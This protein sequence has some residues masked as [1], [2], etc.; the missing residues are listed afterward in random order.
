MLRKFKIKYPL[1]RIM[2]FMSN[3]DYCL[4]DVTSQG[5]SESV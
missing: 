1:S 2:F 4:S 5:V 3:M